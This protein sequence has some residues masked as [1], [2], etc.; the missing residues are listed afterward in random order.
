MRPLVPR[1]VCAWACFALALL[2]P[3]GRYGV[4]ASAWRPEAS[5]AVSAAAVALHESPARERSAFRLGDAAK[6]FGWSTAIGDFNADGTPDV[7]VADHV[8]PRTGGY[9]YRIEFSVSGQPSDDVTFESTHRAIT[10]SVSDVDR[11]NDLDVIVG[12]PLSGETVGVWLNDGRGHFTSADVRQLPVTIRPLQTL[13]T[14]E[15]PAGSGRLGVAPPRT[16]EALQV[17]SRA[18]VA[19]S[20]HRLAVSRRLNL[21]STFPSARVGP[22]A[23][24]QPSGDA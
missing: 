16:D 14:S 11:D 20:G 22:R 3:A 15:S 9:E 10:I 18:P 1:C 23:P 24:P 7:A 5:A 21:G 19:A 13:G 4:S 12:V 17:V 6:P 2:L 8:A